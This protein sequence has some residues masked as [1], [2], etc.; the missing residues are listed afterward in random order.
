MEFFCP[1]CA[2]VFH[3][4]MSLDNLGW[5]AVCPE[6]EAFF[7]V[8]IPD[9]PE[10]RIKMFFMDTDSRTSDAFN[11]YYRGAA[12]CSFYAF[13]KVKDFIAKWKEISEDPESMWYWCYDGEIKDENC[14]CSGAYDPEDI[15][16]FREHFFCNED[17]ICYPM[18]HERNPRF[19]Y[20]LY[21]PAE[22]RVYDTSVDMV[23][24]EMVYQKRRNSLFYDAATNK[25]LV[26]QP[27]FYIK[28]MLNKGHPL[29][30]K[31]IPAGIPTAGGV[32]HV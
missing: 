15:D 9:I 11:D 13:D 24:R 20:W 17:G 28:Q 30:A 4:A 10:G 14:F 32:S 25:P 29:A 8:D 18:L 22:D 23:G 26:P 1:Y 12:V 16:I 27:A 19:T 6:C 5:H 7:D 31:Y 2:H 21:D 3:G